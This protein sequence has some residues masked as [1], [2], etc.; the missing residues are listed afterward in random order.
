MVAI[1][2]YT[3]SSNFDMRNVREDAHLLFRHPSEAGS[4]HL[5]STFG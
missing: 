4:R 1:Y 3:E 2:D 5:T